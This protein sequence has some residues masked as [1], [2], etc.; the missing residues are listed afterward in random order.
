M[1]R[2]ALLLAA[3]LL[4]AAGPAEHTFTLGVPSDLLTMDPD[5]ANQTF[6]Q[7]MLGSI[8]EGLVRLDEHM[9]VEPALATAWSQPAPDT[10]RFTL[11]P[12]VRFHDGRPFTAEDVAFSFARAAA[13]GSDIKVSV[14]PV[15]TVR[16]VDPMTIE[17]T[18]D[19]PDPILPREI[20]YVY[21]MPK[22][23]A[24]EHDAQTPSGVRS[25]RQ[26]F[27]TMHA[28][29]TGPFRLVERTPDSST[30]LARNPDWWDTAH[31]T[32]DRVV[33]RP[34]GNDSTRI[35]A[36]AAG[37]ADM[38][39]GVPLQAIETL[40]ANP[41]IVVA[42]GSDMRTLFLGM[43]QH[44][45]HLSGE[46]QMANPF[47]D[48]RVRRAVYQA[49]DIVAIQ[50]HVMRGMS[51]P[52]G[53]MVAP[54]INGYDAALD[55]RLPYD[56]AASR[57]LLKQAGFADGF[58]VTLD[59]PVGRLINDQEICEALVPMLARIGI[60]VSLN[61]QTFAVFSQVVLSR[62][63]SFYLQSW[64]PPSGDALNTIVSVMA[65]PGNAQ[66]TFNS[67]GYSNPDLD[68][69]IPAIRTELEPAKRDALIAKAM[70]IHAADIGHI[71][72]HQQP[73]VWAMRRSV[74]VPV[75]P[76][77]GVRLAWVRVDE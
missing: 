26:T 50:Q 73:V 32:L 36:I 14:A 15:K 18:T 27:A 10:W 47:K 40:R 23:W 69:L 12:G 33:I 68:A 63:T 46:E 59:C 3:L 74:H 42:Q 70:A 25:D 58:A 52:T 53:E 24:V 56:P 62:K 35:A 64:L 29:G 61:A 6:T 39:Q 2:P 67:G 22:S 7:V 1:R 60:K 16:A 20:P 43:D 44:S 65:T 55:V 71:P 66:G 76:D 30:I 48:V 54:S 51:R 72:L 11:R 57:N 38:I 49:I 17:I 21:V 13:D 31:R 75:M 5:G 37:G 41:D 34:I 9:R 77:D 45:E 8:Y 19:G 28:D 4:G